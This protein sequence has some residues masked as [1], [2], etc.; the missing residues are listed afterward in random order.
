[1]VGHLTSGLANTWI[2]ELFWD[3]YNNNVFLLMEI[4]DFVVIIIFIRGF[5]Q[6][7]EDQE[8]GDSRWLKL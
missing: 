3:K 5:D 8:V 2:N 4:Y 7:L 1:M 6:K